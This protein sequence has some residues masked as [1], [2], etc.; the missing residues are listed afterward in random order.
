MLKLF[1]I[2]ALS[3]AFL[4]TPA[5]AMAHEG[6]DHTMTAPAKT[7]TKPATKTTQKQKPA[8]KATKRSGRRAK[9]AK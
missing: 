8:K 9:T 6:H 1:K 2:V 3:G 4:A 7:A 5:L